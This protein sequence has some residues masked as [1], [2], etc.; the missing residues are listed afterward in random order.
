[1]QDA[2]SRPPGVAGQTAGDMAPVV[3]GIKAT[4]IAYVTTHDAHDVHAW[5]G[6]VNAIA[7]CLAGA[8]FELDL[9]GLRA[10]ARLRTRAMKLAWRTASTKLMRDREPLVTRGYAAQAAQRLKSVD[11]DIVFSPGTVPIGYLE[12]SRPI[13]L[14]TDATFDGMVDYYE[15]FTGLS[16]RT[17][18]NGHALE[19][20]ALDRCNL[21]LYSSEWAANSALEHYQVDPRKVHV[22][23]FGA[24]MSDGPSREDVL[25]AI[26]GRDPGRCA[27]LFVGVDW[28]RKGGEVAVAAAEA[29]NRAGM[30]TE[31]HVV[32]CMPPRRL[33]SF[34]NV[35]GFISKREPAGRQQLAALYARAH[36][37]IGPSDA[38]CTPIAFG[39][40]CCHGVPLLVTDTGGVG[41]LVRN[42]VNGHLL[43]PGASG[44]AYARI[45]LDVMRDPNEYQRL[46][47]G[48]RHEYETRLNW[49]VA[50]VRVRELIAAVINSPTGSK[51]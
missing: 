27:L 32:G 41:S 24:N 25:T 26:D 8:G 48:A 34:V 19:Q 17:L 45:A 11:H 33:P 49:D 51:R 5:S 44:D 46:A 28:E 4:R 30:R 18:R 23:S 31:L 22:V 40:A 35:H 42:G 38:D 6:T 39:E 3:T 36:F 16:R 1:M 9:M 43:P 15:A 29:M 20:S 7:Q 2:R 10:P 13:V 47:L 14:W 50:G 21:A 37:V 12:T